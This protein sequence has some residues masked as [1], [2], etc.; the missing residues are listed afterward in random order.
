[1]VIQQSHNY[2]AIRSCT[3]PRFLWCW[4]LAVPFLVHVILFC[5][6][7]RAHWQLWDLRAQTCSDPHGSAAWFLPW[8]A[9]LV[10]VEA[11]QRRCAATAAARAPCPQLWAHL[12]SVPAPSALL[13][14]SVAVKT[15]QLPAA[16]A[17]AV[18]TEQRRKMKY[19]RKLISD[20]ILLPLGAMRPTDDTVCRCLIACL[21]NLTELEIE[22]E[23]CGR[24][25]WLSYI[26]KRW[27]NV[28]GTKGIKPVWL[29]SSRD[30]KLQVL[31]LKQHS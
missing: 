23:G 27:A 13:I 17:M 15:W 29:I 11:K 28:Q 26:R 12:L 9:V 4:L 16:A 1:M 8:W 19:R 14:V 25:R 7:N 24:M 18:S 6:R 2:I 10:L 21:N 3:Q 5:K 30:I 20:L 22:S 31:K